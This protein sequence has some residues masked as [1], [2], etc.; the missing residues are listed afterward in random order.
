MELFCGFN[1]YVFA[2]FFLLGGMKAKLDVVNRVQLELLSAGQDSLTESGSRSA[3][4]RSVKL[5]A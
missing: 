3:A 1:L 4:C 2:N 5:E